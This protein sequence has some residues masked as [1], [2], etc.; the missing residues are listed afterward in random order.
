MQ[1]GTIVGC[2]QSQEWLLPWWWK[3]YSAHNTIPVSFMDFGLS[4]AARTWCAQRGS[5]VDLTAINTDEFVH[6][7]ND[8]D[9]KKKWESRCGEALWPERL[10]WFKKPFACLHSPYTHSIWLDLDCQ[11]RGSL[12]PLFHYLSLGVEI[13]LRKENEETQ[14]LHQRLGFLLPG[15]INYNSGVIAFQKSSP[16]IQQWVEEAVQR[17]EQFIGDQQA[18]SR[19]VFK[20]KPLFMELP[21]GCN[22]SLMDGFDEEALIHHYHGGILKMKLIQSISHIPLEEVLLPLS[23]DPNFH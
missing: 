21:S 6:A 17:N 1:Q 20:H 2:D 3:H 12:I 9:L 11:V 16:I 7:P 14:Q 23:F 19:A 18:L 15:E 10:A 4:P 22:W 13:A 5:C 8:L